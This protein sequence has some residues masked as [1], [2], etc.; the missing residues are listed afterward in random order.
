MNSLSKYFLSPIFLIGILDATI[1]LASNTAA[2]NPAVKAILCP[3]DKQSTVFFD[4][5]V[6]KTT[7]P[8]VTYKEIHYAH[9]VAKKFPLIIEVA[10]PETVGK[11]QIFQVD[12]CKKLAITGNKLV[13]SINKPEKIFIQLP[14]DKRRWRSTLDN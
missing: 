10:L 4:F 11:E 3:D 13:F 12:V 9:F 14:T 6:N 2:S 8:V 1:G 7:I 5:R